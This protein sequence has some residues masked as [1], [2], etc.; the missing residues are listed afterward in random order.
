MT[1]IELKAMLSELKAEIP[2]IERTI[3]LVDDSDLADFTEN[4]ST[5]EMALVGVIP[6]YGHLGEISKF[7]TVPVFQLDIIE[8]TDY[9][10]LDNDQYVML[11]ERTL[12]IL[13]RVRDLLLAK[14]EDGC[15]PMLS[16]IEVTSLQIDPIKNKSQCNGWSM[17]I[18][19]M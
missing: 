8:K 16:N 10:A 6:S 13:F 19:T 5:S 12:K 9:S 7:R 18:L 3:C 15:Y 14:M 2:E 17:D 11:F 4:L 1:P